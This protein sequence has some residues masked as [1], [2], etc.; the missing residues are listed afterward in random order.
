MG[1]RFLNG[2]PRFDRLA[3]L[4]FVVLLACVFS[5]IAIGCNSFLAP[6]QCLIDRPDK[7]LSCQSFL[8]PLC[9]C[10]GEQSSVLIPL[11]TRSRYA[12][13]FCKDVSPPISC[14]MLCTL[15]P[16]VI[17]A[18]PCVVVDSAK[19][20]LIGRISHVCAKRFERH[21]FRAERYSSCAISL[22]IF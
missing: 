15:P 9:H 14:L 19:S 22:E 20:H 3:F 4:V 18:V 13:N 7:C 1:H 6:C 10:S 16:A 5:L 17:L 2:L 8:K 21:P 11:G 12:A